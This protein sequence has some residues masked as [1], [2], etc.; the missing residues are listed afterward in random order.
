MPKFKNVK[1]F[2]TEGDNL[3]NFKLIFLD[4]FES[5]EKNK[6]KQARTTMGINTAL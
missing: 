4:H 6:K 5:I 2:P 3:K 1:N